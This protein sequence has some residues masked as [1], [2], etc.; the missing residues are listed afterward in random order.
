M[1]ARANAARATASTSAAGRPGFASGHPWASVTV[2]IPSNP[3]AVLRTA[4]VDDAGAQTAYDVKDPSRV[5]GRCRPI[6]VVAGAMW[7]SL[8]QR[9]ARLDPSTRAGQGS[10]SAR[11]VAALVGSSRFG[12]RPT[13]I[14]VLTQSRVSPLFIDGL[15][16][17][18]MIKAVHLENIDDS[19]ISHMSS[20]APE[21]P[22]ASINFRGGL[23]WTPEAV[24]GCDVAP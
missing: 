22:P 10:S 19:N 15:T 20:I 11:H 1:P 23:G 7:P 5:A 18:Y 9:L 2:A 17:R 4:H 16:N 14:G 21:V 13:E 6:P 8:K 3:P 12:P 24:R